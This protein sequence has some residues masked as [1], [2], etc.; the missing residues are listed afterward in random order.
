MDAYP[1]IRKHPICFLKYFIQMHD[2]FKN[3]RTEY[4]IMRLIRKRNVDTI[5]FHDIEA[6]HVTITAVFNLQS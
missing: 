6:P 1:I 4:D 5:I 2:V 3:I